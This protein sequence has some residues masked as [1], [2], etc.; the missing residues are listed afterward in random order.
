MADTRTLG[1][2]SG[3]VGAVRFSGGLAGDL[4]MSVPDIIL[5]NS[6][7]TRRVVDLTSGNNNVTINDKTV[8]VGVIA[9]AGNTVAIAIGEGTTEATLLE[10][11]PNGW[12]LWTMKAGSDRAINITTDGTVSITLIEV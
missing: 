1:T 11:N 2:G 5:R 6:P 8:L 3:G 10:L 7:C 9:P 12:A 4:A